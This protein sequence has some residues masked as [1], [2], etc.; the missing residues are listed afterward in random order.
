VVP[1]LAMLAFQAW[2]HLVRL[3][4]YIAITKTEMGSVYRHGGP[5]MDLLLTEHFG[6]LF[7]AHWP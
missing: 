6:G 7:Q 5:I 2:H 1:I 4:L 3:M